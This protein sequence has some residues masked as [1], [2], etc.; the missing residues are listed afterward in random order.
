MDSCSLLKRVLSYGN[1]ILNDVED[2]SSAREYLREW[3]IQGN[4]VPAQGIGNYQEQGHITG[5]CGYVCYLKDTPVSCSLQTGTTC[6]VIINNVNQSNNNIPLFLSINFSAYRHYIESAPIEVYVDGVLQSLVL[7]FESTNNTEHFDFT[8]SFASKPIEVYLKITQGECSYRFYLDTDLIR[9]SACIID[10]NGIQENGGLN[11]NSGLSNTSGYNTYEIFYTA[12]PN[13]NGHLFSL[14][15]RITNDSFPKQPLVVKVKDTN[16]GIAHLQGSSFGDW[17]FDSYTLT[18][19][20]PTQDDLIINMRYTGDEMSLE[21]K[22]IHPFR[23]LVSNGSTSCETN[24][25]FGI[26]PNGD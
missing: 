3:I 2:C 26:Y 22:T 1:A 6:N 24:I 15:T 4:Q 8:I 13:I 21:E 19:F 7:D 9:T 5:N 16:T 23:L 10:N 17:H 11:Y 18:G 20:S 12:I 14:K 25:Q